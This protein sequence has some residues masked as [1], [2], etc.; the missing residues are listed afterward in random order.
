MTN[1]NTHKQNNSNH[2]WFSEVSREC[3]NRGVT[4]KMFLEVMDIDHTPESVKGF[5]QQTAKVKFGKEHTR[6]LTT[7]ELNATY[8]EFNKTL[9]LFD[10]HIPYPSVENTEEYLNSFVQ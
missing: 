7:Q 5:F 10:I 3:N 6:D 8:E 9:A 2:L 4:Q 1:K